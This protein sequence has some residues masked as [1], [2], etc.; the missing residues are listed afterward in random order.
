[1]KYLL[2][3]ANELGPFLPGLRALEDDIRYPLTKDS[4]ETFV[5]R[6]GESY[7]SFF[8]DMGEP[9]FAL[10]VKG[11]SVVGVVTVV[12]R[13]ASANGRTVRA[14]YVCDL[15]VAPSHRGQNL[16]R[17][18]FVR[19]LWLARREP[20]LFRWRLAYGVAM[21]GQKGD[22][23][24]SVRRLHPARLGGAMATLNI[25]FVPQARL[26]ALDLEGAPAA[27]DAS[28]VL[29]LSPEAGLAPVSTH[30]KK[31]LLV[32]PAQVPMQLEHLGAGPKSW[33]TGLGAYLQSAARR[34][35][36]GSTLCFALDQRFSSECVWLGDLGI[37]TDSRATVYAM[38]LPLARVRCDR[39][40]IATSEI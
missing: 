5:I 24:R 34:A 2:L 39:V 15:K 9:R 23:M 32:G 3:K 20:R 8:S 18:L 12:L 19:G 29:D 10:A 28:H 26:A 11:N 6:H 13:Q 31:D 4:A 14:A 36:E 21:R 30:G 27:P 40:H 1:M 35:P 17:D 37:H 25:Y 7:H 38:T 33:T 22:V 16:A